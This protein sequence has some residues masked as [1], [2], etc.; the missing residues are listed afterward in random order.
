MKFTKEQAVQDLVAKFKVKEKG[1]N[2]DRTIK[3]AVENSLKMVGE[4]DELELTDF[5]KMVEPLVASAV[6]LM[7]HETSET[8]KTL[9]EKIA[10]LEKKIKDGDGDGDGDGDKDDANAGL[11][12]R[13]SELEAKIKGEEEKR[14]VNAKRDAL[15]AKIIE[16]GV[17]NNEWI[18]AQLKLA[19]ITKDTDVE[20]V[21]ND[22]VEM[23][24]KFKIDTKF[25]HRGSGGGSDDD[26]KVNLSGL[27]SAIS[28][29]RGDVIAPK[30]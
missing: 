6:G 26:N 30:Q 9:Q 18:E 7:R 20:T 21:A 28:Q 15:K 8:A 22:Y 5:S 3:E 19:H 14:D 4:N 16:L 1:L 27:S 11:L 29:L 13:L 2:L 25:E 23:F 12:K 10:E 24:N 17:K